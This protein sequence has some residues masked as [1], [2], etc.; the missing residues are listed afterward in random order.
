MQNLNDLRVIV[1]RYHQ[2]QAELNNAKL[3]IHVKK[4]FWEKKQWNSSV[5]FYS[6]SIERCQYKKNPQNE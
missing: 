1:A 2:K 6:V 4:F 5:F 3:L